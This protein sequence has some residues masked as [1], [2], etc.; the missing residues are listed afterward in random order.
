MIFVVLTKYSALNVNLSS[1]SDLPGVYRW[2]GQK[3]A[4]N[5]TK[6]IH[7]SEKNVTDKQRE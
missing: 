3:E 6:N 4:H 2:C 7:L 5:I 1:A